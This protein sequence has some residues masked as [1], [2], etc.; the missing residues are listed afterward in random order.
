MTNLIYS[1][2][3]KYPITIFTDNNLICS[4]DTI[5]VGWDLGR[6]TTDE[7]SKFALDYAE[8]NPGLI[9]EYI[10][11]LA[12]GVQDNEIDNH[13]KGIFQSLSLQYPEE[14]SSA[15]N[16]EW[17][18]WRYCIMNEMYK[19]IKDDEKLLIAI[20]GVYADFDYPEDMRP[21]I[22]YLP[23]EDGQESLE[24]DQAR[25]ILVHKIKKFLEKEKTKIDSRVDELPRYISN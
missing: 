10:S 16:I 25:K 5:K 4:W 2:E 11:E 14:E 1:I 17:R 12:L 13:L 8:Q 22:Y 7:I 24:P 3:A 15:W 21:M 6:L 20:E 19:H 9:N 18:K 23:T